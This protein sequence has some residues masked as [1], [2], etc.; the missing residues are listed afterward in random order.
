MVISPSMHVWGTRSVNCIYFFTFQSF[1]CQA[2]T[3]PIDRCLASATGNPNITI[4][5]IADF[6]LEIYEFITTSV[7]FTSIK[8]FFTVVEQSVDPKVVTSKLTCSCERPA[9]NAS[10]VPWN[11]NATL[12]NP[13]ASYTCDCL[14]SNEDNAFC[15]I[16]VDCPPLTPIAYVRFVITSF[17]DSW[18]MIMLPLLF[19]MCREDD[20]TTSTST[21]QVNSTLMTLALEFQGGCRCLNKPAAMLRFLEIQ[22]NHFYWWKLLP[23]A[24]RFRS[25]KHSIRFQIDLNTI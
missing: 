21:H 7:D 12:S 3:R 25:L 8:E 13:R 16:S 15:D 11:C 17:S 18:V 22:L 14:N 10:Q 23:I 6:I 20:A 9:N 4:K 19:C 1:A 5:L 2:V 24:K